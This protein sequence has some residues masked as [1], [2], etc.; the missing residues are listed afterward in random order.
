MGASL[1]EQAGEHDDLHRAG[2]V[3]DSR[4]QHHFAGAR[5]DA[6]LGADDAADGDH[7]PG[8]LALNLGDVAGADG[9][10]S[11]LKRHERVIAQV[12][13]Q[14]L[15]FPGELV[16]LRGAVLDVLAGDPAGPQRG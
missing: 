10:E 9:A 11:G 6:A 13:P 1:V 12:K 8:Q 3:L 7:A 15:F 4:S 14:Q 5:G 16:A 2:Q